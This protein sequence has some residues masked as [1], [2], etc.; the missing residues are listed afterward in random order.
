[1]K[2][3]LAALVAACVAGTA[4]LAIP[5]LAATR[6]VAVRDNRFGPRA[7]TVAAGTTVKWAW[8]GRR[9]HNVVV[10]RGPKKFRSP[11][12]V[13]GTWSKKVTRRGTYKLICEVHPGMTM[14]LKVR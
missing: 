3:L 4:L 14:T 5:A 6:T 9:G 10:S 8:R 7:V 12:K 1:M 13:H 11:F 2:K